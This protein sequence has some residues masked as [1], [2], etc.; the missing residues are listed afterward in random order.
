MAEM[1]ATFNAADTDQDGLLSHPE[2]RDFMGKIKQN[3][4]ARG[5]PYAGEDEVPEGLRDKMF[6]YFVSTSGEGATGITMA[7]FG[8]GIVQIAQASSQ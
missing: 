4:D 8:A 3:S 6:A 2:F 1:A 5:V 7:G